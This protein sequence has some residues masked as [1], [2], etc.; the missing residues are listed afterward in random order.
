MEKQNKNK[1]RE[2]R[3]MNVGFTEKSNKLG[4]VLRNVHNCRD[5]GHCFRWNERYLCDVNPHDRKTLGNIRPFTFRHH[6][7]TVC[8]NF[9]PR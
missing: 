5:C 9:I 7:L 2:A 1:A 4:N 6:R 3:T 8:E